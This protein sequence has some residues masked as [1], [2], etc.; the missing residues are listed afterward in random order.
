MRFSA[1]TIGVFVLFVLQ[2]ILPGESVAQGKRKKGGKK[3]GAQ[4]TETAA[5]ETSE[6]EAAE[7]E[8]GQE[9]SEED[10]S[11]EKSEGSEKSINEQLNQDES[12]GLRRPGRM[13]FDERLIKGQAAKSGAVYLFK[14]IPRHL[15]GLVPMRRSYRSRIVEPILG[16]VPLKPARYSFEVSEQDLAALQAQAAK[17]AELEAVKVGT[18]EPAATPEETDTDDAAAEAPKPVKKK[19]K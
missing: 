19:K 9:K 14:R 10:G 11:D 2:C 1:L 15:P 5:D 8:T 6:G 13:E 12:G 7:G 4:V 16:A 17:A 18:P 3:N